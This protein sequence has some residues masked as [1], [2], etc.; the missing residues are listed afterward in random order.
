MST[1][2][3]CAG[4]GFCFFWCCIMQLTIASIGGSLL[5]QVQ[6]DIYLTGEMSHHAV[7]DAI[8][9]HQTSVILCEHTN[10]ERGYLKDVLQGK[11]QRILDDPE[12]TM[13][14]DRI[15]VVVSDADKEPIQTV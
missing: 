2:A 6:A 13:H 5:A 3:I 14:S 1:I 12:E 15:E 4:S 11:L 8:H 9:R 7:L 10:T